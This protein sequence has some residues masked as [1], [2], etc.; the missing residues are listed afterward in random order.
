MNKTPTL[1]CIIAASFGLFSSLVSPGR[2]TAG[3]LD[4]AINLVLRMNEAAAKEQKKVDELDDETGDLLGRYR[5]TQ[6][7][8]ESLKIYNAQ[9]GGLVEA[10]RKQLAELGGKLEAATNVG[11]EITPLLIR[12]L[13]VLEQFI[14]LD[15]PFLLKERT[16]RI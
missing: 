9:V 16:E 15:L 12:M 4:D 10:Q 8:I 7:R 5:T 1:R 3:D 6:Q 11:R 2:S 14:K 13:D